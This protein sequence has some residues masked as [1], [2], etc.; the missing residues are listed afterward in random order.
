MDA[1]RRVQP[2]PTAGGDK[3]SPTLRFLFL[4]IF[5]RSKP[6][7]SE[8]SAP[9]CYPRIGDMQTS[10]ESRGPSG[11]HA[12]PHIAQPGVPFLTVG[13]QSSPN[14]T[15]GGVRR[16][17]GIASQNL[18]PSPQPK[19]GK[20]LTHARVTHSTF[21]YCVT[22][23]P[24]PARRSGAAGYATCQIPGVT[25]TPHG[26]TGSCGTPV[27]WTL[28]PPTAGI[29]TNQTVTVTATSQSDPTQ[30]GHA[31]SACQPLC[32]ERKRRT[33]AGSPGFLRVSEPCRTHRPLPPEARPIMLVTVKL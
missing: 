28:Y 21:G 10:P 3:P 20:G 26:L 9:Q 7:E 29:T 24:T 11:I 8:S 31:A 15:S 30:V 25:P 32:S 18:P 12:F 13:A 17:G 4:F 19:A 1:A 22:T 6:R 33:V 27:N 2:S 16:I 14:H 5:N 23:P